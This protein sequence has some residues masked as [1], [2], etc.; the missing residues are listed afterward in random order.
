MPE[1]NRAPYRIEKQIQRRRVSQ[2]IDA[3]IDLVVMCDACP[4]TRIWRRA[5]IARVFAK[6]GDA[7]IEDVASHLTCSKCGSNWLQVARFTPG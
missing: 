3:G 2:I 4:N 6:R 7:S 1:P 5:E